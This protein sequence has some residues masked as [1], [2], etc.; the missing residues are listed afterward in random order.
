VAQEHPL[1]KSFRVEE[2]LTA[3]RQLNTNWDQNLALNHLKQLGI[4]LRQP[5]GKLSGGQQSQVALVMTLA[6]RPELLLLDEP[7][8]S[9]DPLA[10]RDFQQLLM[11]AVAEEGLSVIISSHIV[12]DLERFCDHLTILSAS[13]VQITDTVEHL[14]SSHKLLVGPRERAQTSTGMYTVLTSREAARQCTLLVQIHG[15]VLD[16]AWEVHDVSL[17]EIILAYLAQSGREAAP[18]ES[19]KESVTL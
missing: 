16:P 12:A 11:E 17:E 1:Y 13:H 10:R 7:A 2:M 15:Q 14:L 5:V 6:K 3:G 8:A 4:S 19:K 9:L 18:L